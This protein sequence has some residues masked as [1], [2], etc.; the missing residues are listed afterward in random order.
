MDSKKMVQI[1]EQARKGKYAIPAINVDNLETVEAVM[2]AAE[3]ESSPM[4]ISV[5][6]GT[7][8][9][10]K[11]AFLGAII[12]KAVETAKVPA[13][14]HLDHG[15]TAEHVEEAIREGCVSVMIDGSE[16]PLQENIDLTKRVTK[17]AH[18]RGVIVEGALGH[19]GSGKPGDESRLTNPDEIERFQKETQVD[20]LSVSVGNVH[21]L[22]S[23]PLRFDLKLIAACA[24]KS[25]APLAL[26]G[27]SFT[28]DGL[29]RDAIKAGMAK[30]NI[31]TELRA[32]LLRGM[33]TA[34]PRDLSLEALARE[35]F[36]RILAAG[37]D[38]F[39]AKAREK[40][41]VLGSNGR[42]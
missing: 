15:L 23:G 22:P 29:L 4:F 21:G 28:P 18:A 16:M 30:V 33:G 20:V 37:R 24:S 5:S 7:M 1:I 32:S 25:K 17:I 8:A 42:V 14:F 27:G 34:L 10:T 31:G 2:A 3:A 19:V 13:F 39:I 40:I 12:R 6:P 11:L 41:T 38:A 26:H 35:R 9:Y 36:H